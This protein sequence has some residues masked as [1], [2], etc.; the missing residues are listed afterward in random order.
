[1]HQC[2]AF[3][4]IELTFSPVDDINNNSNNKFIRTMTIPTNDKRSSP[5][6]KNVTI[7]MNSVR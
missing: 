7:T 6:L 5:S 3:S 4:D 1:M 2:S